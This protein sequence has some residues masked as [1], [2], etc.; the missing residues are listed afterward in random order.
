MLTP[1]EVANKSFTKSM[2]GGYNMPMVDEFLDELTEDYTSLYKENAALKAKLKVLVEKVE[3]YR[4]TEEGMRSALFTAQKMANT[5]VEDAKN[6]S[7]TI[8]AAAEE[9]AKAEIA[10]I[11]DEVAAAEERANAEIAAAEERAN[12]EIAAL[13]ERIRDEEEKLASAK[14]STVEFVSQWQG[15]C[16]RQLQ[17]LAALPTPEVEDEA[18]AEAESD[19]GEASKEE[20]PIKVEDIPV[21]TT[22]DAIEATIQTILRST[23]GERRAEDAPAAENTREVVDN[24]PS[25]EDLARLFET[26]TF[27]LDDLQFGRNYN[28]GE[29]K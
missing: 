8:T 29:Q 25:E 6:R 3:E 9:S 18:P 15:V 12:A 4:A 17:F 11:Q 10:R 26:R 27:R 21:P 5:M 23:A 1:Q 28:G 20:E 22:E 24:I 13:R 19:E 2:M 7:A 16:E 14:S